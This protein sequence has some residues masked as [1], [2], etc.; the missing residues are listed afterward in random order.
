MVSLVSFLDEND[1]VNAGGGPRAT[2]APAR[3]AGFPATS[4][5]G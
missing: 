2:P 4:G 3:R 5:H 1:P